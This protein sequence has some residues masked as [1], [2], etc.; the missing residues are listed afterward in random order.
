MQGYARWL[1]EAQNES[2]DLQASL[3]RFA[4]V[5]SGSN[6]VES[7][8]VEQELASLIAETEQGGVVPG[9]PAGEAQAKDGR[10]EAV[11]V[12]KPQ[13]DARQLAGSR[14]TAA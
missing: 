2:A 12:H 7:R 13:G 3:N 5:M 4:T 6:M 10:S 14:A 1:M 9:V 11:V 8:E